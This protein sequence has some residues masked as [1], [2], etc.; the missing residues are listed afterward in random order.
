MSK[1]IGGR[2]WEDSKTPALS[3]DQARMLLQAPQG[4]GVKAVRD[5][6]ILARWEAEEQ[7]REAALAAS[8]AGVRPNESLH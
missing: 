8:L 7:A 5:R 3:D 4:D 2:G 6:A 1:R